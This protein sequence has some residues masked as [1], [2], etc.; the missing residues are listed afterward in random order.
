MKRKSALEILMERDGLSKRQAKHKLDDCR[1][2]VYAALDDG[3]D[4]EV[5]DIVYDFLGLDSEYVDDII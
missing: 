3:A 5:E 4:W 2:A 1:E